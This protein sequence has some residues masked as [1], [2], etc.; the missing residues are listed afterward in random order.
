MR[1]RHT[2]VCISGAEVELVNRFRFH[3]HLTSPPWFRKLRNDC[4]SVR[5]LKTAKFPYHYR[6]VCARSRTAGLCSRLL[7]LPRTSLINIYHASVISVRSL[8][9]PKDTKRQ[10][11]PAT[12]CSPAAVWQKYRSI[13][14]CTTRL[15]SSFFPQTE[16]L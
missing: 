6:P 9:S 13:C 8:Q 7:K 3:G 12:A 14:S 1:Q 5:K 11:P 16:R 10:Y 2:P 15:Q 4:I